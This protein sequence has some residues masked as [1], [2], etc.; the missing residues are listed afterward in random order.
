MSKAKL[1]SPEYS[2]LNELPL[3]VRFNLG[4]ENDPYLQP[5]GTFGLPLNETSAG[6]V[7]EIN[8]NEPEFSLGM[9]IDALEKVLQGKQ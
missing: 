1:Y 3:A 8:S 7:E 5:N 6:D 9:S 2:G 4:L